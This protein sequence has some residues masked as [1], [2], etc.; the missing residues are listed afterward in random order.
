MRWKCGTTVSRTS[1][2]FYDLARK[3]KAAIVYAHDKDFPE[4]DEPTAEF[5][6][7]RLMQSEWWRKTGYK[8]GDL[9]CTQ[10]R[11]NVGEVSADAF[12]YFISRRQGPQSRRRTG[13]GFWKAGLT[14]PA[15][16]W[17]RGRS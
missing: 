10:A 15:P 11:Q 14:A 1:G 16:D 12:V 3:Y 2:S 17:W 6:Y 9:D 7:A 8:P 4:I 13:P 5:T